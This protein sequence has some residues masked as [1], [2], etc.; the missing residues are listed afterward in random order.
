MNILIE[1]VDMTCG[2]SKSMRTLRESAKKTLTA[3]EQKRQRKR[4]Y[5]QKEWYT[6]RGLL[7]NQWANWFIMAGAR[8]R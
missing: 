2:M 1:I 5:E 6:A 4:L 3:D 8:E 7:G